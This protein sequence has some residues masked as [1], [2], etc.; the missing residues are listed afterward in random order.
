MLAMFDLG[1]VLRREGFAKHAFEMMLA[2]IA[3][4]RRREAEALV[5]LTLEGQRADQLTGEP[6]HE[7]YVARVFGLLAGRVDRG[8]VE[9]R[10]T[11]DLEG[12]RVHDVG[13]R[14]ALGP[15]SAFEDEARL[16]PV[17]EQERADHADRAGTDDQERNFQGG[18]GHGVPLSL[19]R[20]GRRS[21]RRRASCAWT[22]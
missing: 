6:G 8:H 3:K 5:A 15:V 17:R 9:A 4:G 12:A 22:V 11:T 1:D 13:R 16:A 7:A 18:F 14:R 2:E 20:A 19:F 10:L 21:C